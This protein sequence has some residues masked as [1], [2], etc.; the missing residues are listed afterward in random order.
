ML[1][2]LSFFIDSSYADSYSTRNPGRS[3]IRDIDNFS[4]S[5]YP[6]Y[7]DPFFF[8]PYEQYFRK[9]VLPKSMFFDSTLPFQ[10]YHN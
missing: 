5:F 1:K 8:F 3:L 9:D 7:Q 2:F 6:D 4:Y 10:L